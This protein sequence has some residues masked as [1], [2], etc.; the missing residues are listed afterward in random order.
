MPSAI[1]SPGPQA[2]QP[3]LRSSTFVTPGG[4]GTRGKSSQPTEEPGE[5]DVD[6][7]FGVK[8]DFPRSLH[9]PGMFEYQG[10]T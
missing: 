9:V 1:L 6:D 3:Y 2:L 7:N 4:Q 8:V 10:V 5:L